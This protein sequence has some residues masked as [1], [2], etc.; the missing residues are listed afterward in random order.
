MINSF[1]ERWCQ[2]EG[3]AKASFPTAASV[4][5]KQNTWKRKKLL[6]NCCIALPD[7][8]RWATAPCA[9]CSTANFV[10]S[11]HKRSETK[12]FRNAESYGKKANV[13]KLH[14]LTIKLIWNKHLRVKC[15]CKECFTRFFASV[16]ECFVFCVVNLFFIEKRLR[17]WN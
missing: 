12:I 5:K 8:V 10:Q 3:R 11:A 6:T 4:S 2:P 16:A 17:Y 9:K 14:G 13:G 7:T 1:N 15:S